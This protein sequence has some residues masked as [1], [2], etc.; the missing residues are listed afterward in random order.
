MTEQE[1]PKEQEELN[2][3]HIDKIIRNMGIS[4]GF[5]IDFGKADFT[6]G[7]VQTGARERCFWTTDGNKVTIAITSDGGI[8]GTQSKEPDANRP[9]PVFGWGE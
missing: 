6:R 7:S 9:E 2:Q 4:A 8:I 5:I 3:S 1:Y